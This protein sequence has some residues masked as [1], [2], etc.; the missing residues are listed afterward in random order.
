MYFGYY[1]LAGYTDAALKVLYDNC[2]SLNQ[3]QSPDQGMKWL[4]FKKCAE[5]DN[6]KVIVHVDMG[7]PKEYDTHL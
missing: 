6:S 5:N 2:F 1:T 3:W 4:T 7:N